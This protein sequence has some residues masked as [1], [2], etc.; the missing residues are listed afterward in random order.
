M[1]RIKAEE[2]GDSALSE[3][4]QSPSAEDSKPPS[5]SYLPT[6]SPSSGY[7]GSFR[8]QAQYAYGYSSNETV[9]DKSRIVLPSILIIVTSDSDASCDV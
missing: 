8:P 1:V 9:S 2:P 6:V 5:S 7:T 3:H 4:S